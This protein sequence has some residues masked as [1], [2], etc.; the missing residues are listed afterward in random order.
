M[1]RFAIACLFVVGLLSGCNDEKI[2]PE[3]D[4]TWNDITY[5]INGKFAVLDE[6]PNG[7]SM[8]IKVEDSDYKASH[9]TIAFDI[10][11]TNKGLVTLDAPI[12]HALNKGKDCGDGAY[13]KS[14]ELIRQGESRKITVIWD[15]GNSVN[16][17][18]VDLTTKY[19]DA[20]LLWTHD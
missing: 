20:K 19:G 14:S 5:T 17:E 13:T 18:D 8:Y 15:C 11:V 4:G 12:F 16:P 3:P 10:T 9:G 2:T 7:E 1:K 6:G